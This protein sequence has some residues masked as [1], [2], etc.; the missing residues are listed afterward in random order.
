MFTVPTWKNTHSS[1]TIAVF[2]R[3]HVRCF[4][5]NTDE[6]GVQNERNNDRYN[7]LKKK[8]VRSKKSKHEY[9]ECDAWTNMYIVMSKFSTYACRSFLFLICK[10]GSDRLIKRAPLAA[11]VFSLHNA[12]VACRLPFFSLWQHTYTRTRARTHTHT[13]IKTNK[14]MHIQHA[15]QQLCYLSWNIFWK[16]KLCTFFLF[17]VPSVHTKQS[18]Q[19]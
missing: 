19:L 4:W 8:R 13:H 16:Y 12:C 17:W 11:V 18:P 15:L 3:R 5:R 1:H 6:E 14:H 2:R 10:D 7:D 9:P